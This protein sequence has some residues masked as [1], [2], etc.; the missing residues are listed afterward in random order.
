M[1][2][3]KAP[4]AATRAVTVPAPE[5]LE[6]AKDDA[7]LQLRIGRYAHFYT[8]VISAA[9]AIDG[10]LLLY[11]QPNLNSFAPGSWGVAVF[12]LL[13]IAAGVMLAA[14]ALA[15]KWEEYLL[16]PWEAHFSTS[17]A[18]VGV[19]AAIL[20]VFVL[21]VANYGPFGSFAIWPWYYPLVLAGISL[22][23][24]GLVLTW[25]GWSLRQWAS[26]I[27]AVIPVATALVVVFPPAGATGIDSALAI[28]LLLSA[29]FYQSSGSFLHLISSGT[30]S[31][32]R[33]LITSGQT[34][35]FRLA[36]E[37]RAKEEALHFREAALIKR[38]ADAENDEMSIKRQQDSLQQARVQLEEHED[39]YRKRSDAVVQKEREWAGKIA[40]IDSRERA[41]DDKVKATELREQ[42][43]GRATP[44]VSAREQ[45]LVEREGELTKR[46]VELTQRQQDLD[47]RAASMP[48]AEARLDAR[49]K[50]L[51]QKTNDLLRRE[52]AVSAA[53]ARPGAPARGAVTAA[54][55]G[56]AAAGAAAGASDIASREV[57]LQ[58][59]KLVLDEQNVTLGR[60][61]R[62]VAEKT[63]LAETALKASADKEAALATREAALRQRESDFADQLKVAEDRRGQY[64]AAAK[65][66]ETRLAEVGKLQVDSA[67]KSSELDRTLKS[68]ADR[69]AAVQ[70]REKQFRLAQAGVDAR[71]REVNRR[72]RALSAN[73]AEVSLRRQEISRGS[74]LPIAGLAAMA[75]ADQMDSVAPGSRRGRGTG[76]RDLSVTP[77]PEPAVADERLHGPTLRR[78]ADRLPTGTPR[79]DDLLLGG[80]PPKSHVVL[81]GEAFVGKEVVLYAFLAEGL[82]RGEP[83]IIVTA[84]RAPA[85]VRESMGLVLP[86]FR[87]YEQMGMVTWIDASGSSTGAAADAAPDPHRF[88]TKGSDDRAGIMSQLVKAAKA[89]GGEKDSASR[90]G[91]L[92][93]SSV[94][95]HGDER[96]SSSF[97]QN[98]V[99]I[100][101]PRNALTV[102][103]LEAG[104]LSETQVETLL[105]RMD[106]AIVF[107]QDR[108]KTF[109]S[110]KGLGD[111]QTRD[112]VECRATNRALIVGSFALERI[113]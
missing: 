70:D 95:A 30:R 20:V 76:V 81:V 17:V 27:T 21:H 51:D 96:A 100:L 47:R 84:T 22:S 32:E 40:D 75:A 48:E 15:S 19:N 36:E 97:L 104:A 14:V 55:A 26:A 11:V 62:D 57:K 105:G 110:V 103:S 71:E 66:Y 54:V 38:E 41:I 56:G 24:V 63:K 82:K 16:W 1:A 3:E 31:H 88:I 52:G 113:R 49:R 18:A 69:E 73:E 87:E 99:G 34:R 94:L 98:M 90:V 86:Q 44:L 58:Q 8:V 106:G 74:D 6:H 59:F 9:L 5:D 77:G 39:D 102:Y 2:K 29:I 79:M 112:W 107:R 60:K 4:V 35:M 10:I 13:P 80:F 33:E 85:E 25:S 68:I 93:L 12:L 42:E 101:K 45:R 108:D 53:E 67:Q 78:I 91:F 50:E 83:A 89:A 92:G 28:S 64:E 109:L 72:E 23:L 61:A 111:V 65:D 7:L 46:E 37:V 43:L